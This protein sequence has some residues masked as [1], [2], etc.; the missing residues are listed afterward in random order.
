MML[1][2][3]NLVYPACKQLIVGGGTHMAMED[4]GEQVM[5]MRRQQQAIK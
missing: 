2:C 1:I 3:I 4:A 5:V